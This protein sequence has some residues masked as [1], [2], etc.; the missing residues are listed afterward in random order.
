MWQDLQ[1]RRVKP[2]Q[3][4]MDACQK[5]NALRSSSSSL[6]IS[7]WK[8]RKQGT[9]V[10]KQDRKA[11]EAVNIR[12]SYSHDSQD[13][14]VLHDIIYANLWSRTSAA[15][16]YFTSLQNRY[17]F[18]TSTWT[19]FIIMSLGLFYGDVYC[20]H[21][22]IL[23]E[24]VAWSLWPRDLTDIRPSL[25]NCQCTSLLCYTSAMG[26]IKLGPVHFTARSYCT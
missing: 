14:V 23:Y 5:L 17:T 12:T 13:R 6:S 15:W 4:W 11:S 24:K 16:I 26:N 3:T 7:R 20:T 1:D 19:L 9:L 8:E 22:G 25:E 2:K 10:T 18:W 21:H